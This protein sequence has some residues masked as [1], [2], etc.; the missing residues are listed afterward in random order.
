M[1]TD[2]AI[3]IAAQSADCAISIAQSVDW[4]TICRL[5]KFPNCTE[6]LYHY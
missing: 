6:H 2:C 5:S 4:H 3:I 1:Y